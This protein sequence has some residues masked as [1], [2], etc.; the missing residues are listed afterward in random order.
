MTKILLF[1]TA[2]FS[3]HY[4]NTGSLPFQQAAMRASRCCRLTL[5]K[6]AICSAFLPHYLR[7]LDTV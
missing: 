2:L 1:A 3:W 5:Y 6:L 4:C 7:D